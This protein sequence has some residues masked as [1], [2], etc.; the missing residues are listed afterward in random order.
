MQEQEKE[1]LLL[2]QNSDLSEYSLVSVRGMEA[3][4]V[5]EAL[6]AMNGDDR[7]SVAAYLESRGAWVTEIA[8]EG[9]KEFG[10]YHLD[11]RYNTDTNE[12]TDLKAEMEWNERA[13]EPIG[14]DD[15]ILKITHAEGFEVERITN[16]TPEEVQEI[17]TAIIKLE[18]KDRK[19]IHD[20]LESYGADYISSNYSSY[21]SGYAGAADSRKKAAATQT[22]SIGESGLS[23]KAQALLEKLRKTYGDMDFMVA[24]FDKGDNA[25]EI[26]SRGTKDVSV[27]FSSSELEKMASDGKYEQEYMS[28]VQGAL[29]MS[30]RINR[31]FGFTS[32]SGQKNGGAGINRIGISFTNWYAGAVKKNPSMVDEYEKQSEE[33]VEKNV[34]DRKL[35]T[36]FAGI[37]TGNRAVFLESLKAFQSSNPDFLASI[38]NRELASK[39]WMV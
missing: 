27:I 31:E 20:C 12:V 35:D 30:E 9:T 17:M 34:K 6:Y 8:N 21:A 19:S 3:D 25:K 15:V 33:Y 39:F 2:I 11:V 14:A 37:K 1:S 4:E 38:I 29:R 5:V 16:K 18:N 23:Q 26:L 13:K 22:G 36:T 24:D 7:L 32:V 28:Q 10:E